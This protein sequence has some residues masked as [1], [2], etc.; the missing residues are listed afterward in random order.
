LHSLCR[1][2]VHTH[3]IPSLQNNLTCHSKNHVVQVLKLVFKWMCSSCKNTVTS[4]QAHAL[5]VTEFSE[6]NWFT[7]ST[8]VH[9]WNNLPFFFFTRHY[10]PWWVLACSMISF[11]NLPSLHFFLQ[12]H[13][14]CKSSSTWFNHLNL[15]LPT[16]LDEH[17]SHSVNFWL[18]LLYPFWLHVLPN[19]I[20]VILWTLQYFFSSL[21][22]LILHLFLSFMFHPCLVLVHIFF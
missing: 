17:G 10:K 13:T 20:F 21:D 18:F 8:S 11:H 1:S 14:F 12:F 22:V 4:S 9:I 16:G 19:I 7:F 3:Q 5:I 6:Q 2:T 15:G